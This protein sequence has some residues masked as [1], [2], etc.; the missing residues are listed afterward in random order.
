VNLENES[1]A[2]T[3][4]VDTLVTQRSLD[5]R[6]RQEHSIMKKSIAFALAMALTGAI[7]A[8]PPSKAAATA[9]KALSNTAATTQAGS[10]TTQ[11]NNANS[12]NGNNSKWV[13]PPGIKPE[14]GNTS[15]CFPRPT[16][17]E[18]R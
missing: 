16:K 3:R 15:K 14:N 18:Q 6:T 9:D 5:H 11:T 4:E 10:A 13:C 12:A 8:A 2:V 1:M 7:Q 17:N